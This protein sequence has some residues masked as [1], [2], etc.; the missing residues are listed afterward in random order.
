[1]DFTEVIRM[2]FS[3]LAL[4]AMAA[5]AT[6]PSFAQDALED[7]INAAR[8]QVKAD[9]RNS[10]IGA[11]YAQMLNFFVD[12]SISASRL[13]A[14][15]DDNTR[16]DVFKLPLQYEFPAN[17][18][19]WQLVVR[20]TLSH[21]SAENE[22]SLV[23]GEIIDGTWEADSALIGI[24][25]LVPAGENLTW[26]LGGQFGISRLENEADYEG[27]LS[28]LIAPVLD[29]VLFNWDTNA[30]ISSL[31]GGLDYH[32]RIADQYKVTLNGRYTFS[33]I[34]SYSE[35]RDLQS[36]SEDTGTLAASADVEHPWGASLG[37]MPLFGVARLGATAFTGPSRK[38]LGFSH[39]YNIGYSVGLNVAER[40]RYFEGFTLGAQYNFGSDV[41]GV[42]LVFGWRLK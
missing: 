24:G 27:V 16:Y 33:H 40:S 28:E 4:A 39:F 23:E 11:G 5:I 41:D 10:K 1:V 38:A 34:A 17:D 42:S 29:G 19:G 15:A 21:A 25:A 35:S 3:T 18:G 36:F 32:T 9:L 26:F 30:R 20:G 13:D 6:A 8:E 14:D 37:D 31:T 12:P 22:F 7:A 2:K